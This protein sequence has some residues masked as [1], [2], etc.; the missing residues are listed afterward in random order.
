MVFGVGGRVVLFLLVCRKCKSLPPPFFVFPPPKVLFP[1]PLFFLVFSLSFLCPTT[2]PRMLLNL[3][4]V[5]VMLLF[6]CPPP[7]SRSRRF[8]PRS[9]PFS[10]RSVQRHYP[11]IFLLIPY[12][13]FRANPSRDFRVLSLFPDFFFED[14][15][16]RLRLSPTPKAISFSFLPSPY[17]QDCR[18]IFLHTPRPGGIDPDFFYPSCGPPNASV[19]S[20]FPPFFFLMFSLPPRISPLLLFCLRAG[21]V[22]SR[23]TAFRVVEGPILPPLAGGAGNPV[24]S[25]SFCEDLSPCLQTPFPLP[26]L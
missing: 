1:F 22:A 26:P 10:S 6:A 5:L 25:F 21:L 20:L 19:S 9:F 4:P 11:T 18:R 24:R 3:P 16:V 13:S 12:D 8:D 2:N 14:G 7:I 23:L 17:R 15:F